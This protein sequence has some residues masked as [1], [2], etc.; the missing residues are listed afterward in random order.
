MK[1]EIWCARR[2]VPSKTDLVACGRQQSM[3]LALAFPF[4]DVF[5]LYTHAICCSIATIK[6]II[7]ASLIA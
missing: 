3:A 7:I 1:T 2:A 4:L 5:V 6:S